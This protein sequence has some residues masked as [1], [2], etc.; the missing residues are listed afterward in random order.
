[1]LVTGLLLMVPGIVTAPEGC[2]TTPVIEIV[3]PLSMYVKFPKV[4]AESGNGMQQN[5]IARIVHPP[6]RLRT[7]V[8]SKLFT[9][10]LSSERAYFGLD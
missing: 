4:A 1:M 8:G 5:A 2:E 10:E 3:V 7:A 6:T 9:M